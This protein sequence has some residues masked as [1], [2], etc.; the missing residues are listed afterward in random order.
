MQ[1]IRR[2]NA[3]EF[4]TKSRRQSGKGANEIAGDIWTAFW[5]RCCDY[6]MCSPEEIAWKGIAVLYLHTVNLHLS[7]Y[8]SR[9]LSDTFMSLATG[10]VNR[11][12]LWLFLLGTKTC[13]TTSI[14]R[15]DDVYTMIFA[16]TYTKTP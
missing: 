12:R 8:L 10:N 14:S 15:V 4:Q 16:S 3:G 9:E 11:Y 7:W 2:R 6:G 13:L 1:T 5:K